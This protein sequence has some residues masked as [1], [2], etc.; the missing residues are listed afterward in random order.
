MSVTTTC[1]NPVDIL[2]EEL[3]KIID[4]HKDAEDITN[5]EIIGVLEIVKMDLHSEMLND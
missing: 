1:R 4:G 2:V 3:D 5:A